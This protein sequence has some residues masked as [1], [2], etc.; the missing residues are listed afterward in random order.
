MRH[1]KCMTALSTA[2]FL[3]LLLSWAVLQAGIAGVENDQY[4]RQVVTNTPSKAVSTS[5]KVIPRGSTNIPDECHG[6]KTSVT[7][8][9]Q[10]NDPRG[11]WMNEVIAPNYE[12]DRLIFI[13]RELVLGHYIDYVDEGYMQEAILT[14]CD[15]KKDKWL[16]QMG[17]TGCPYY[18]DGGAFVRYLTQRGRSWEMALIVLEF[19]SSFGLGAQSNPF[20]FVNGGYSNLEMYCD[21]LDHGLGYRCPDDPV[22]FVDY[23][24]NPDQVDAHAK[25]MENFNN[26]VIQIRAFCP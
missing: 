8:T 17:G 6:N 16:E 5:T 26:R 14:Y 22:G 4:D 19:E 24:H 18:Q 21:F 13:G 20:G 3:T 15:F 12:H 10:G 9:R 11:Y 2:L 1:R 7:E 23:Y 25:Y